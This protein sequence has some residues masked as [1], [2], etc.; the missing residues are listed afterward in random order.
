M[1]KIK[2]GGQNIF[3][4]HNMHKEPKYTANIL[5]K[6]AHCAYCTNMHNNLYVWVLKLDYKFL[7]VISMHIH[8]YQGTTNL[9][10]D[11]SGCGVLIEEMG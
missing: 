3:F 4:L 1:H 2:L 8:F 7:Q 5:L 6:K 11:R 9:F 10:Q